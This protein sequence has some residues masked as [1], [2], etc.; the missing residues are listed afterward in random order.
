MSFAI[1]TGLSSFDLEILS[2]YANNN[3]KTVNT[4]NALA[5]DKRTVVKH[6]VS[7]NKKT[8]LNPR[9]FWDL[10]KLTGKIMGEESNGTDTR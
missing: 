8:G 4:A 7:I 9:R 2:A 10:V 1:E 3:M 6:L 5:C